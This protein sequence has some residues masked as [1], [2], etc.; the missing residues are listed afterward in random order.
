MDREQF[1]YALQLDNQLVGHDQIRTKSQG[2]SDTLV[3]DRNRRLPLYRDT[4]GDEL[5]AETLLE[6][7]LEYAGSQVPMDLNCRSDDNLCKRVV[8]HTHYTM[9]ASAAWY[10]VVFVP[11]EAS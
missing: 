9:L 4:G 7:R 6:Y 5:E 10:N 1:P 8:I 11:R 3:D 2:K